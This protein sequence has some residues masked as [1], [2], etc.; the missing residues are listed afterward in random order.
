[1]KI[2]IIVFSKTGN[3]YSTANKLMEKLSQKG[4]SIKLEKLEPKGEVHPGIKNLELQNIPDVKNYDAVIFGSP[5]WAFSLSP[6]LKTYMNMIPSLENKK[7]ICFV[8]KGLPFNWTGGNNSISQ[9]IKICKSKGAKP[10]ATGIITWLKKSDEQ[11]D[12]LI[13]NILQILN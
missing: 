5:V 13:N 6:V 10:L 9:M 3:T 8:T 12:K 2:G 4:H 1:M 7:V 11:I